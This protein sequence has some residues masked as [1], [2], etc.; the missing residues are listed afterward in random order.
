M[1]MTTPPL[2]FLVLQ[3][4]ILLLLSQWDFSHGFAAPSQSWKS[5]L[6]PT[7]STHWRL[8]QDILIH[9]LRRDYRTIIMHNSQHEP[10]ALA[11]SS[12][13]SSQPSLRVG[14][15]GAGSIAFGTASLAASLGHDPMIWSPSGAGTS[16]LLKCATTTT[17]SSPPTSASEQ[18]TDSIMSSQI[19]STGALAQIFN[20]R[21]ARS[22]KELVQHNDNILVVA[23]PVNGYKRVMEELAPHVVELIMEQQQK[24]HQQ[25]AIDDGHDDV[26]MHIIISSHASLGAVYFMQL[27]RE[28]KQHYLQRKG[29]SQNQKEQPNLNDDDV[30]VRI[31]AWG[32]T[33]ITARKTSGTSVNVLTVRQYVDF[34]TV[35]SVPESAQQ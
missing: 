3:T 14:I 20:V 34:C 1:A 2:Q 15:I 29:Q 13:P 17:T 9:G 33:V 23:L 22:P 28:E 21:I 18:I 35:P 25:Q 4:T 12:Q 6:Q 11:L 5:V 10:P 31:T 16:E 30:G 32:T 26:L 8:C 24:Q 27:L 7:S 19:Q